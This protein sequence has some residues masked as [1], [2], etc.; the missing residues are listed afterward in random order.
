MKMKKMLSSFLA[1]AM[2]MSTMS[3]SAFAAETDV[4]DGTADTA[5]YTGSEDSYV[6][7]TAEELA[8]LAELVNAGDN[9]SK[10]TIVLAADIDLADAE[11]TPI[12]KS[13]AS[14]NGTFNGKGNTISNLSVTSGKSDIGLFG[15][16]QNGEVKNVI[17]ENVTL[18]G[19]LNVGAVAGTP[20]TSKYTNITVK[21]DIKIDG[22]SYVGG[23]LGKNVY[24]NVTNV[25]VNA[26]E[27][28]YVK[29][30]STEDGLRYRSY[31]GGVIGFM[32]EGG[33]VVSTVTSNIDVYGDVCDIGGIAG[34]AH[35][36]NT[37]EN[38]S[39]TGTV[40]LTDYVD[41]GDLIEMGGIVGVWHD[42][43]GTTVKMVGNSFGGTLYAQDAEGNPVDESL[44]INN[45][46]TG[47]SYSNNN[48]NV[49]N[50]TVDDTK[51]AAKIGTT[52]YDTFDA[53]LAAATAKSGKVTLTLLAD[54]K[55]VTGAGHGSTPM[56]PA[57]SAAELTIVGND[58]TITAT[59]DGVGS[60]RAANDTCLTFNNVNFKDESVS[61]AEDAW[62]FTYLEFAGKLKFTDCDFMDEIQLD[63]DNGNA[64]E[65]G[66]T[67]TDCTFESNEPSVYAV[68]YG[69]G[70]ATFDSC[71]FTGY[72]GLKIHE[73][74]GSEVD[75][76]TVENCT[77]DGLTKKPGIAIGDLNAD[78]DITLSNN[79][80]INVQ[81]GDQGAYLLEADTDVST[82]NFVAQNN[83][84]VADG[85]SVY[86]IVKI[87]DNEYPTLESA[88]AAAAEGDTITLYADAAPVLASQRSITKATTI[89]L[90]GNTL[91]LNE[92]DLYFGTTT[93]MNGNIVVAPSVKASTAVFWMF[94]DQKLTFD[95]VD[96]TATGV[97]G[98]YLMGING[99]TGSAINLLNGTDIIIDNDSTAGL[100]AVICDNGN[101]N[102]VI[103]KDSNIDVN[104]I[105][106]RFYL[107]G[108]NGSVSV[109]NSII[110]LDGVKEGF[111]L[112][113]GQKLDIAGTSNVNVKLNDT[114]GR[115]GI[116]ITDAT[117]IY[118]V[119]DTATVNASVYRVPTAGNIA[120]TVKLSFVPT[121]DER[122]Y[123]IYV[124]PTEDNKTINRLMAV[125][126]KF[127]LTSNDKIGYTLAP[128]ADKGVTLT[129]DISDDEAYV[130]NFDGVTAPDAT[131]EQ[132]LIGSVTFNG[133]GTFTF[134]V[135]DTQTYADSKIK[136]ALLEDNIVDE[137]IPNGD[138]NA[139]EGKFD[140]ANSVTSEITIEEKK[141]K[142]TIGIDFNNN[143]T[144]GKAADYND[145][146]VTVTGSNGD[147]YTGY[148]GSG[149]DAENVKYDGDYTDARAEWTF[150]VV[151]G[152]RYTVVVKGEGYRTARYTTVVD[153]DKTLK[154]WNNALEKADGTIREDYIE[155]DLDRSKRD[156][157][158]LAGDIAQ[159][160]IIDKYDLA[161]V[162]SYFGYDDKT[163]KVD[164]ADYVKYDLN[165]DGRIDADD[166]SYV[167]V[168]WGK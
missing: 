126:T 129:S 128:A 167:L 151:S 38:C 95:N 4:W 96:I 24:A 67:F 139:G 145:M 76:V 166:I 89:D 148:V 125:Q 160:N 150:D 158:F 163:E 80:L 131:G 7:D 18:K 154:F 30:V 165:R 32:G 40:T 55:W 36:G 50:L 47:P 113:A 120:D 101:G 137:Y 90:N 54:A 64:P 104:K 121:D 92:D 91:T 29:A 20:Y 59:G 26:N 108:Q 46:I 110:D 75:A 14:F 82:F 44:Y 68:W 164:M 79:K 23:V 109:E 157:T 116:N 118:T 100:T 81:P 143:I 72:R 99:G 21:G 130:F 63:T 11:W 28:S 53:A 70:T 2:V 97:T 103:I 10:K 159:D 140:I 138:I 45:T 3:F 162:V 52:Y 78:T 69:D 136:T 93:F 77:F 22:M 42:E 161:A 15:F 57:E 19:R 41:D 146:W 132:I 73:A 94:A 111:L 142:L 17:V 119:A 60:I 35:Y 86:P 155:K 6:L 144:A 153:S 98:T 102:S 71:T 48:T 58:Y 1:A 34:I 9:F 12:G 127:V 106:G 114:N 147:V 133:T 123:N 107:G 83:E 56:V 156:I 43:S 85:E 88:F 122:V 74:Y 152:Y 65:T 16:T 117:A 112:R 84:V 87:G 124:E 37:F 5:W 66:A 115:Y 49:N 13:G 62:E 31:V 141:N 39:S 51:Y 33:H 105:E 135:A 25:T 8:G 27:G 61:Y 134:G 168:S 149:T